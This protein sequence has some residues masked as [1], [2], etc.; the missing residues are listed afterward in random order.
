MENLYNAVP[1]AKRLDN[2]DKQELKLERDRLAGVV[3]LT[4]YAITKRALILR[5][6]KEWASLC[7]AMGWPI[8][9]NP[10]THDPESIVKIKAPPVRDLSYVGS[11]IHPDDRL[12]PE[13]ETKPPEDRR[14]K[15]H[16]VI[17]WVDILIL[18]CLYLW[19]GG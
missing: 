9:Y 12:D 5:R 18:S 1:A 15:L 13:P 10:L 6:N 4:A 19:L 2:V 17:F 14:R 11:A 7:R 16:Y 8:E 3:D